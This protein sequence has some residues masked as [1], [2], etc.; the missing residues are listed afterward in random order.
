MSDEQFPPWTASIAQAG[1]DGAWHA[2]VRFDG[3]PIYSAP[4]S[5]KVGALAALD[6]FVS[7]VRSRL[8]H[9]GYGITLGREGTDD[10][11][12]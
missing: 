3:E 9:T 7:D 12:S 10:V 6:Q 1:T 5:D 11:A 2:V 8:A 4:F